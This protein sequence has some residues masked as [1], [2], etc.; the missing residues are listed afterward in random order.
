MRVSTGLLVGLGAIFLGWSTG[1]FLTLS[2]LPT[3]HPVWVVVVLVLSAMGYWFMAR[4]YFILEDRIKRVVKA[5][6]IYRPF[7]AA[8]NDVVLDILQEDS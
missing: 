8:A 1:G 4:A 5:C 2:L 7:G 3:R 6:E